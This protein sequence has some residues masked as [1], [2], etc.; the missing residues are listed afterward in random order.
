MRQFVLQGLRF[1]AVGLLNTAIG[2]LV[3]YALMYFLGVDP[4]IANGIG[5]AIA[6]TV[7]FTLNRSWT[8]G[9]SGAIQRALPRYVLVIVVSYVGNFGLI[10][11]GINYLDWNSYLAQVAGIIVYSSIT[12]FGCRLF[13]FK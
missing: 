11:Y 1:S 9:H 10:Y 8:F 5:Y 7:S 2:L 3:I 12:F 13:V 6:L 4:F